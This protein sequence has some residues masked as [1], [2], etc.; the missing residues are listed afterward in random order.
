MACL[1]QYGVMM[2]ETSGC[3]TPLLDLPFTK[4]GEGREMC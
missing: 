2:H 3:R 4:N 1:C